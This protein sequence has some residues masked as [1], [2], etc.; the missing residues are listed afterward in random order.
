MKS[1]L[2]KD[3]NHIFHTKPALTV[4]APGRVNFIGEHTDYNGGLVMPMAI[5]KGIYVAI[6]KNDNPFLSINSTDF[7]KRREF[8]LENLTPDKEEAWANCPKGIAKVIQDNH[9]ELSGVD[10]TIEGDIPLG[11]GLSSSAAVEVGVGFALSELFGLNI[12]PQDLA[13]MCQQAEHDFTG[14]KC[15]IMDQMSSIFGKKGMAIKIDCKTLEKEEIPL[16]HKNINFVITNTSVKHDLSTGGYNVRR[17]EC[18]EIFEIAKS[19]SPDIETVSDFSYEKLLSKKDSFPETL[20]HRFHHILAENNRVTECAAALE[21]NNF[22]RVGKL[23]TE[24]HESLADDYEVSCR[25]LDWLVDNANSIEGVYGS[26]MT[27]GGFGGCTITMLDS[28]A[29]EPYIASL[30]EYA[31]KFKI[32]PEVY[33]AIPSAGARVI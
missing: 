25:E 19:I 11:A 2:I 14:A 28:K 13:F 16:G 23:L 18:A 17:K 6:S 21:S 7:G 8:L 31:A 15:G 20:Y 10:I 32:S 27:G 30:E 24:S 22:E 4:F 29:L 9:Y 26:R 1:K 33:D 5:D 12:R 3:H